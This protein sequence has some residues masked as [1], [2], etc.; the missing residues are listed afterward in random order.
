[1]TLRKFL[2]LFSVGPL[3]WVLRAVGLLGSWFTQGV[4]ARPDVLMWML[5]GCAWWG[6]T[7]PIIV[8]WSERDPLRPG[9]LW[10]Q[11]PAHFARAVLL[12]VAA[13]TGYWAT[14][15]AS[16]V[17]LG[18]AP[19]TLRQ[20]WGGLLAT[21]LLFDVFMYA[22]ALVAVSA[23][24]YQRELRQKEL[25]RARLE[26]ALVQTEIKL[27][28]AELDPH[29]LFNALNTISSLVH[30]DPEAADR[31]ICRL[32]DFLRR[33][34]ATSGSQEVTLQEELEH[35]RSYMDVQMVRFRGRLDLEV[36]VPAE[37]LGCRVPNLLLQPLV[38]NVVKHAVSA[39]L[40]PVRATVRA[41]R[42]E[43]ELLLEIADDGPGVVPASGP[44]REGIGLANTRGRLQKLYEGAHRLTLEARPGGGTRVLV[45]LPHR[46]A[47]GEPAASAPPAAAAST[48]G[49]RRAAA[50]AAAA[51]SVAAPPAVAPAAIAP[52]AQA[53]PAAPVA[54]AVP[55]SIP[56]AAPPLEAAPTTPRRSGPRR[57]ALELLEEADAARLPG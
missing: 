14:R 45:A 25:D 35:L 53:A 10:R 39:T 48:T 7:V 3:L 13:G 22:I 27:F 31:M 37:L 12:S 23:V 1:M 49:R 6:L 2:L 17:W 52:A 21:W 38:E 44:A 8:I 34:F 4:P 40:R 9:R 20:L 26:T 56:G 5:V 36:D 24:A 29:F 46:V 19:F 28:K 18:T 16:E 57:P 54:G 50:P 30:R 43:D 51:P 33:S 55:V 42:R 41:S 32:S 11:V 15:L 47:A